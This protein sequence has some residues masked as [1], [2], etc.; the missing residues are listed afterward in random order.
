MNILIL[1]NG[2]PNY[3]NFFN[4]LAKRLKKEKNNIYFAV[5]CKTSEDENKLRNTGI[6]TYV[7]SDYFARHKTSIDLLNNYSEFN[8]NSALL[9]D[10]ERA[11]IYNLWKKKEEGFFEKLKSALLSFLEELIEK[12]KIEAII[13]ENVS[14]TFAHF[15]W[16]ASNKKSISYIGFSSS[17]LPG[18]Y[19]ISTDPLRES[20][21]IDRK[22]NEINKRTTK[23][24]DK[25]KKWLKNY[26]DNLEKITPDYMKFNNLENTS[27][28]NKYLKTENITKLI[29]RIRHIR[30]DH[31]HSFQRGNP[32]NASWQMF[33]RSLFRKLR[34]SHISKHYSN[35]NQK[36]NFILYPIHYHP[37]SSTSILAG[38]YLNEYEVI[39]NISFNLPQ[40]TQLYVKD[41]ISAFGYPDTKFYK[42]IANLPN[43][44][45]IAPTAPTKELI[46]SSLAV[47]TLTSTVGYE[48]LL[49]G[50]KVLLLG[51]VFYETHRNIIKIEDPKKIWKYIQQVTKEENEIDI[52]SYNENYVA[53]YYLTTLP[54]TL[55]LLSNATTAE[56][57]LSIHYEEI[58]K[59]IYSI[60]QNNTSPH[61]P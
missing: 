38:T 40:N 25:T 26:L 22:L 27:L 43:V 18:R 47:I 13:Y 8:M 24:S 61:H 48:A 32:I 5:D 56:S 44:K 45:I 21:I 7:F 33:K 36:D 50:K 20:E 14:N 2:A 52:K 37:E 15:A 29:T 41:H 42:S 4:N 19:S 55:N 58:A 30:D 57:F 34:I 9:S 1:S 49:L 11:D 28:T 60:I 23:L 12:H 3:Y 6:P 53:A 35:Y 51:N 39:R 16:F 59:T 46:K 10:F 54:G 31:H 17:R